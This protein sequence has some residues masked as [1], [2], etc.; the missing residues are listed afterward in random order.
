[1]SS[2]FP[3]GEIRNIQILRCLAAIFVVF[4]HIYLWELKYFGP[5]LSTPNFLRLG[6][7]GVDIFF[8]ISGF[9]MVYIQPKRL[10]EWADIRRFL[11]NRVT[12]I[13]PPYWIVSSLLLPLLY[14]KPNLFNNYYHNQVDIIRSYLL[15]P[16]SYTPLLGVG[17][18]LIH[19]FYFYCIVSI[20]LIFGFRGRIIFGF[21][22][23]G[24]IIIANLW[25]G[26]NAGGNNHFLQLC[27][28][29]FSLTF[30]LGYFVGIFYRIAFRFTTRVH[31]ITLTAGVLLL[32]CTLYFPPP[33]GV[34]PNN[35]SLR[36]FFM[37][38]LPPLAFLFAFIGLE[39]NWKG[40][41][42]P[43]EK[44][45]NASYSIYLI[46]LPLIAAIDT[47]CSKIPFLSF[48][49]QPI[50]LI[51]LAIFSL[52]IS[53]CIG[54]AFHLWIELPSVNFARSLSGLATQKKRAS[55]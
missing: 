53:I 50:T 22:W 7:A 54:F 45:G 12:R 39:R 3:H 41:L 46:H 28:S 26:D 5:G 4:Y 48:G 29:P 14:L 47:I 49:S 16:Q 1:M 19:E 40:R 30:I 31:Y 38:G 13:F 23:S 25:L 17:W 27:L 24:T 20:A 42:K 6:E 33:E 2:T 9:I 35:N 34:Y 44:L 18:T 52:I 15:L 11:L 21:L 36:R 37:Y 55:I 51:S 43:L 8:A 32:I 10:C